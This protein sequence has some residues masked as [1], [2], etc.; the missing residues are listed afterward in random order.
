MILLRSRTYQKYDLLHT[1]CLFY[2][3]EMQK[4]VYGD[5]MYSSVF[6]YILS[7]KQWNTFCKLFQSIFHL[8]PRKLATIIW[9]NVWLTH[10]LETNTFMHKETKTNMNKFHYLNAPRV[11]ILL[12]YNE[13][14]C[15]FKCIQHPSRFS[16]NLATEGKLWC[17]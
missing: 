16:V 9:Y 5:A 15:T 12:L 6:Q 1:I 8:S 17:E 10:L 11:G 2:V 3:I 7:K 4:M 14:E 13:F